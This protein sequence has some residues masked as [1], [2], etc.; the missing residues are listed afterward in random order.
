VVNVHGGK[1]VGHEKLRPAAEQRV[2]RELEGP[3]SFNRRPL[4]TLSDE[5]EYKGCRKRVRMLYVHPYPP[6]NLTGIQEARWIEKKCRCSDLPFN[7]IANVHCS[8]EQVGSIGAADDMDLF[9]HESALMSRRQRI[10]SVGREFVPLDAPIECK[11]DC[12]DT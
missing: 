6:S 1:L 2:R 9:Y 7:V 5:V 11:C 10:S 12:N 4:N 8:W 3:C